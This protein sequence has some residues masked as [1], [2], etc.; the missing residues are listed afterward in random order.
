MVR[1]LADSG[2]AS[3][4]AIGFQL[5]VYE[6]KLFEAFNPVFKGP[7]SRYKN[8]MRKANFK[9]YIVFL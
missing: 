7:Y 8:F 5:S 4:P 3:G 2:F 9:F 6:L 1:Q